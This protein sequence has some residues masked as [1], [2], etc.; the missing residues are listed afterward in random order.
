MRKT[1][2]ALFFAAAILLGLSASPALAWNTDVFA[3]H[4]GSIYRFDVDYRANGDMYLAAIYP[5]SNPDSLSIYRSLDGGNTWSEYSTYHI[6]G[7]YRYNDVAVI[8]G[9]DQLYIMVPNNTVG[10]GYYGAMI[11][12]TYDDPTS[13]TLTDFS[14]PL[15]QTEILRVDADRNPAPGDSM[16]LACQTPGDTM[17]F[18]KSVDLGNTW[19]R[20]VFGWD[21]A[22]PHITWTWHNAWAVVY[23]YPVDGTYRVLRTADGGTWLYPPIPVDNGIT[24]FV[25]SSV[26]ANHQ[27]GKALAAFTKFGT[28]NDV[29]GYIGGDT[30]NS[31][32][33]QAVSW[34]STD[35]QENP[36]INSDRY[37]G[38]QIDLAFLATYNADRY[39]FCASGNGGASGSWGSAEVVSDYTVE[40][41]QYSSNQKPVRIAYAWNGAEHDGPAVFYIR[42]NAP[43]D[44][45]G[46]YMDA[47]W[48]LTGIS[49]L[50]P[51]QN[52]SGR[53][54][55]SVYPNPAIGPVTFSYQLTQQSAVSMELY[56]VAG[57]LITSLPLGVKSAGKH[58]QKWDG[59]KFPQGVYFYKINA[60]GNS[61]T[62]KIILLK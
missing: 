9:D 24:S 57:Q 59:M 35:Y 61:A 31:S 37:R 46:I 8:C 26:T 22:D 4:A 44:S 19:T 16:Y 14:D 55:S 3:F 11:I 1:K 30:L 36:A 62:G 52:I 13:Y 28:N 42:S 5:E 25:T 49:G 53:L 38:N 50:P 41:N 21:A 17:Y 47:P 2:S 56:N 20:K 6:G 34:T 15:H 54:T 10:A 12:K 43:A 7:G 18:T 39:L 32:F 60:G 33:S 23:Q 40:F 27:T 29:I 51:G 45:S 58:Q 48:T